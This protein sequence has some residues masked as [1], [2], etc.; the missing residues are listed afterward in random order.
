VEFHVDR[1]PWEERVRKYTAAFS[2]S[3]AVL[4]SLATFTALGLNQYH[5]TPPMEEVRPFQPR[6]VA[7]EEPPARTVLPPIEEVRPFQPRV[8]IPEEPPARSVPPPPREEVRPFQPR[9]AAP[10]EQPFTKPNSLQMEEA[11]TVQPKAVPLA[12]PSA[13]YVPTPGV[14]LS[15]TYATPVAPQREARP[16][17]NEPEEQPVQAENEVYEDV[18]IGQQKIQLAIP[19]NVI[20]QAQSSSSETKNKLAGYWS[21]QIL[22]GNPNIM[23]SSFSDP[24][25]MWFEVKNVILKKFNSP[26]N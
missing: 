7:P 20:R 21:A 11:K 15:K 8:V 3:P 23:H 22:K 24:V 17:E 18:I 6:M 14:P 13:N 9:A 1:T 10:P 12:K 2:T 16:V 5:V 26:L 4:N 19:A 25:A